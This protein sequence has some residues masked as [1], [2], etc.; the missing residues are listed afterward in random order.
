METNIGKVT[1]E[2]SLSEKNKTEFLLEQLNKNIMPSVPLTEDDVH[3]RCMYLVSDQLNSYG[4]KFPLEELHRIK[5]LIIDSPLLV[6]HQKDQ[7]PIGRNFYAEHVLVDN[8]NWI[9]CFFYWLK[10][11]E[12]AKDL[13]QNIDGGVIKECSIGFTFSK[14][15][16][17]ICAS[18]IR[19]CRHEPFSSYR[20][21]GVA[22]ECFFY[23]T[24]IEKVLEASL[25]YRG[26]I[27]NTSIS[28]DLSDSNMPNAYPQELHLEDVDQ[29]DVLITPKYIGLDVI[30]S[31]SF[32][33]LN[34]H[35]VDGKA[36]SD[37]IVKRYFKEFPKNLQ[38]Q[39]GQLIGFRG[40][41]RCS[42][43]ELQKFLKGEL[44]IVK[45][46]ELK[47]FPS[48]AL[49]KSTY[50]NIDIFRN[51]ICRKDSIELLSQKLKTKEGIRIW[52]L[53]NF[54]PIEQLTNAD[55]KFDTTLPAIPKMTYQIDYDNQHH[56]TLSL[57]TENDRTTFGIQRF[58]YQ[59]FRK[60]KKFVAERITNSN[61]SKINSTK[62]NSGKIINVE[63]KNLSVQVQLNGILQGELYI[64][65][66][67]INNKEKFQI[68]KRT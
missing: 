22:Q 65:P 34:V 41:E 9:K 36:V 35:R 58:T 52:S 51:Q 27:P 14:P 32:S 46:I 6:G 43:E 38:N 30:V 1:A 57:F 61:I 16:C 55:D 15:V 21:N 4:G 3:I 63:N 5:E 53:H 7:L 50:K 24:K 31:S 60:G 23:Y 40:K 17:S 42:L 37:S 48:S 64:Q 13:Q 19:S 45:R 2:V 67:R 10:S 39:F 28:N 29:E 59:E 8:V 54:L 12:N 56:A 44:S 26:A 47:L 49:I 11:A 68:Y 66:I 20:Q 25:V 18:D 33:K 62:H